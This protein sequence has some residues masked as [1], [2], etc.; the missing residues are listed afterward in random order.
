MGYSD[1]SDTDSSYGR[2]WS[3][4]SVESFD[5]AHSLVNNAGVKEI[6]DHEDED[7]HPDEDDPFPDFD[8]RAHLS[9]E[10]LPLETPTAIESSSAHESTPDDQYPHQPLGNQRSIRLIT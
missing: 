3:I 1:S 8:S 7:E 10:D 2:T 4:G 5:F 6:S 9:K